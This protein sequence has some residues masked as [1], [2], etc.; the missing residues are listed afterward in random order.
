MRQIEQPD[1]VTA[2]AAET[3][4]ELLEHVLVRAE[5]A[6]QTEAGAHGLLPGALAPALIM[7]IQ[8]QLKPELDRAGAAAVE[9]YTAARRSEGVAAGKAQGEE[10]GPLLGLSRV[11]VYHSFGRQR[12]RPNRRG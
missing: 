10:L 4:A 7:A 6:E 5:Q 3:V 12:P 9:M 1:W 8:E 11:G 2:L